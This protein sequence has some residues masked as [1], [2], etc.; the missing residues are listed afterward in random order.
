MLR[1]L[2]IIWLLIFFAGLVFTGFSFFTA[3]FETYDTGWF[4]LITLVALLMYFIRRKQRIRS[5][6]IGKG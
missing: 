6:G 3:G 1:F 5:E 2:E 4:F